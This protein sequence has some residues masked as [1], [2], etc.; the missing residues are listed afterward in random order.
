VLLLL[1]LASLQ[2]P[3]VAGFPRSAE[4][5]EKPLI[6][7]VIPQM[8]AVEMHRLWT[9]FVERI[10]K[11]AGVPIRV[12]FYDSMA[13]FER[14]CGNGVP[15]L[16][17]SHPAMLAEWKASR[18]YMPLVRDTRPMSGVLFVKKDS[19]IQ[20]PS[21]IVDGRIAFVGARNFCALLVTD[22][23]RKGEGIIRFDY[24]Y[25]GSSR[26]VV[27]T[28]LLGKADAGASLDVALDQES[29]EVVAGLRPILKTQPMAPHPISAHPRV[30]EDVRRRITEAVLSL[31][32]KADGDPLLARV[33]MPDPVRADYKRDYA[34][35]EGLG[36]PPK[37]R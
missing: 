16:I 4:A 6:F 33:K 8:P 5:A 1:L 9:P 24:D 21:D 34:A 27:K 25:A 12:K 23:L 29:P 10:S 18:G 32:G 14:E 13:D 7:G 19:K 20:K 2:V 36:K 26:N 28:V 37:G 17:F 35:L 30:P 3:H 31:K 11:D 15:D 22:A